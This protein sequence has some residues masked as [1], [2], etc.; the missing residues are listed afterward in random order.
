MSWAATLRPEHKRLLGNV[1]GDPNFLY[2][3]NEESFGFL[4]GKN[5]RRQLIDIKGQSPTSKVHKMY[6]E[7]KSGE[8]YHAGWIIANEWI[9]VYRI[10][11]LE[12]DVITLEHLEGSSGQDPDDDQ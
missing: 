7:L 10:I 5:P 4:W 6:M 3:G 1:E 2:V 8:S 9:T 12:G 11:S